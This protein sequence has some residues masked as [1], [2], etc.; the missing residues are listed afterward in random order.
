MHS[1]IMRLVCTNFHYVAPIKSNKRLIRR[2]PS[3]SRHAFSFSEFKRPSA[4]RRVS[5][6]QRRRSALADGKLD[7]FPRLHHSYPDGDAR[8]N[9]AVWLRYCR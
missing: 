6:A 5:T 2:K 3:K 8:Q 1:T 7:E 9:P 4:V